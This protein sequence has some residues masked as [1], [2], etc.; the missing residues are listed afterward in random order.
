MIEEQGFYDD[1][2]RVESLMKDLGMDPL[3]RALV[4]AAI[5]SATIDAMPKATTRRGMLEAIMT[6]INAIPLEGE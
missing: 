5:A 3:R 4:C 1:M 2:F 6:I